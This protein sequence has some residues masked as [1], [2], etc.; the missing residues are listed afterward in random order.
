MC[1]VVYACDN[2]N[3]DDYDGDIDGGGFITMA[4]MATHR[5]INI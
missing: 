4:Y 5:H 2:S 1:F 3:N